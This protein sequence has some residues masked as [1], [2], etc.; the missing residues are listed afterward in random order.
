MGWWPDRC[1]GCAPPDWTHDT[2][3]LSH[4]ARSRECRRLVVV[5][6][7]VDVVITALFCVEIVGIMI[8]GGYL[9]RY[10]LRRSAADLRSDRRSSGAR[11]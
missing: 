11:C 4:G 10:E 8:G 5:T 6:V 2:D 7:D 1:T 3:T 9:V